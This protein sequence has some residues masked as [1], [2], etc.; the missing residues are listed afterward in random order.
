MPCM[1]ARN[2]GGSRFT[3]THAAT[4]VTVLTDQKAEV[5]ITIREVTKTKTYKDVAVKAKDLAAG[6]HADLSNPSVDVTV[7]AGASAVSRLSRSDIVPYVDLDGYK[8]GTY[9]VEVL[10]EIPKG[11][12]EENFT[13]S[14]GTVTVTIY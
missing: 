9:T 10:F 4:G 2:D 8:P 13:A 3:V 7:M 14:V 1:T 6:L 11:L 5:Y 12:A